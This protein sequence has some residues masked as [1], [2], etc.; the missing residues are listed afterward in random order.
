MMFYIYYL[1]INTWY[2]WFYF[3]PKKIALNA[4]VN[5]VVLDEKLKAR[6]DRFKV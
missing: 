3:Q 6:A 1:Y 2:N 5:S 4:G